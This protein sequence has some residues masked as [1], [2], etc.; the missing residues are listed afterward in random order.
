MARPTLCKGS[1][2]YQVKALQAALNRAGWKLTQ[3]G[4]FGENTKVAVIA[5]QAKMGLTRDG[6]CGPK[7]WA[8]LKPWLHEVVGEAF[9]ACLDAIEDMP[10]YKVLRELIMNE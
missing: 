10:T 6:I 7:T 1:S 9:L 2:G 5:F 8:K 3:D 4:I